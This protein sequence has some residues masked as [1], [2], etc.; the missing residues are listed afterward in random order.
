MDTKTEQIARLYLE[1]VNNQFHTSGPI[2]FG[3]QARSDANTQSDADLA[4]LL[5]GKPGRRLEVA[6]TMADMAFD[7]M[8]QTGLMIDALPLWEEEWLHPETFKNPALL[9][10]I[11]RDGIW[12]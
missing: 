12:L 1:R 3:S 10:N 6:L 9:E 5:K 8:L 11:R 4:I 7:V 2:L